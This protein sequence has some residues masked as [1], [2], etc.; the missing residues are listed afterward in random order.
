MPEITVY[1]RRGC[2]QCRT[3]TQHLDRLDLP[4]RYVDVDTDQ[5]G[6]DTVTM[7]GYR[8]LPVVTAGD[9]HWSGYRHAHIKRLAENLATA[10]DP[11]EAAELEAA[12]EQYLTEGADHA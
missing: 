3:T 7:L 5:A 11:A 6:A 4:Y 2:Q 12:A 8:T 9:M 1:G 10:P